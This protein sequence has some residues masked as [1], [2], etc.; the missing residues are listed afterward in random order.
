MVDLRTIWSGVAVN[1]MER[2]EPE[3]MTAV[4]QALFCELGKYDISEK[5]SSTEIVTYNDDMTGYTMFFCAKG[6]EGL[7]KKTLAYYKQTIDRF[8]CF[9]NKP[10]NQIT[11]DDIRFYLA[12]RQTK[13]GISIVTMENERRNLHSFFGW[14]AEENYITRNICRPIKKIKTAKVKKKAFTDVE[15]QKIKDACKVE[16]GYCAEEKSKRNIAL[17]EFLISTGCRAGEISGLKREKVDLEH[18]CATVL[19]KGNKER[20]VYLSEICKMRLVEYWDYTGDKEYAFSAVVSG[21]RNN[22]H[23]EVSGIEI[24]VRELGKVAGV[25]NCHPHRFR[26]TCATMA[27]KKG[28]SIVDVQRMLGHE[29]LDTTKIYLDLDNSDLAYQHT[30]IFG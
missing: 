8:L 26:R 28:M 4:Q 27:L 17:I 18:N 15:I 11:T 7:S 3:D 20:T 5:P 24:A 12:H 30:K 1:L 13:D 6:V 23:W 14:L 22:F 29:N 10:I 2:L 25:N 9:I 21:K 16:K 19:G